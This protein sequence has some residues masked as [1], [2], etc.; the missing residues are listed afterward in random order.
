MKVELREIS[1]YRP[2]EVGD[3]ETPVDRGA[4]SL[5]DQR[6]AQALADLGNMGFAGAVTQDVQDR[7]LQNMK[8]SPN[9]QILLNQRS[10][11]ADE[12]Q[13]PLERR[14]SQV[15]REAFCPVLGEDAN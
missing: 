11:E 2:S 3:L 15:E 5:L 7:I 6:I 13:S 9:G 10:T 14:V 1:S 12:P 4:Q 8:K